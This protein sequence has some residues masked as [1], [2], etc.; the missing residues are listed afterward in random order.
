M[1]FQ[2]VEVKEI[3]D[4]PTIK[5]KADS[6]SK[7]FPCGLEGVTMLNDYEVKTA[8]STICNDYDRQQLKTVLNWMVENKKDFIEFQE[9]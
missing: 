1:K 5:V 4:I 8:I 6:W 7:I 3:E 2:A 9:V